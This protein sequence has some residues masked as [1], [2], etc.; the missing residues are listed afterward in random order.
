MIME[1]DRLVGAGIGNH[2]KLDPKEAVEPRVREDYG[3]C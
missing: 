1:D 3:Q 2:V